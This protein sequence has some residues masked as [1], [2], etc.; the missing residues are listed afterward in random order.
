MT[1]EVTSDAESGLESTA[2][3][4]EEGEAIRM[5]LMSAMIEGLFGEETIEQLSEIASGEVL[6]K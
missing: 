6:K 5:V 3:E 4:F 1:R 2:S